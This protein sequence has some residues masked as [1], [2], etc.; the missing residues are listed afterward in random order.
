MGVRIR[1][2]RNGFLGFQ[3]YFR[4]RRLPW[5]GTKCRADGPTHERR[6]LEAKAVLIE[7]DLGRGKPFFQALL[8]H[9]GD[10]P[11]QLL[12]RIA[13]STAKVL[14]VGE[15]YDT[16]WIKRK[17]VPAVRP[18]AAKR[19]RR[20]FASTILP[21]W[22]DV[23]LTA[24]TPAAILDFRAQLFERKVRDRPISIKTVRNIIDWHLRALYREARD[25]D[26][27]VTGDPFAELRW[28]KAP[29]KKPDPFTE[30]E[31]NQILA[32][33]ARKRPHWHAFV[34]FQFWT[35]CRP[36]E[37]AALRV[38]D[39]DLTLGTVSITKSRDEQHEC[40]PKTEGSIREI[41]L[42]PNVLDV[43]REMPR[44][45]ADVEDP[46]FFLNP[47]G[48]P[49]TT[50]WWPKKSWFPVLEKLEIRR[51]KFYATRHTFISVALSKGCNLK[52]VAEYCGTSVE[53]IEKSYGKFIADDGAAPLIRSLE[54][55]KT[56][57]FHV[58][59][60]VSVGNYRESKVVPGGIEPPFA[61]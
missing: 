46:Y 16:I 19:H 34:Y 22:R 4:G 1:P 28:P 45:F 21:V 26:H 23:P 13:P 53:M 18:S 49:I 27:L 56:H 12:P 20:T 3:T 58:P 25:V 47:E 15:Y 37:T 29:R 54:G 60:A 14:T 43:L 40:A 7:G 10:C 2:N 52:W 61:T 31:R 33:F 24:I 35:G 17:V 41:K 55:A 42:L 5:V 36:S 57:T 30:A 8:D 51:R 50:A 39:V 48:G 11:P 44:D 6:E 32:F 59:S 38:S 9:L